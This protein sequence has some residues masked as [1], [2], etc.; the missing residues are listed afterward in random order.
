MEADSTFQHLQRDFCHLARTRVGP[1][2]HPS[3]II[4]PE[5]FSW[6]DITVLTACG[7]RTDDG[8]LPRAAPLLRLAT[9]HADATRVGQSHRRALP[10]AQI[11]VETREV[12][13]GAIHITATNDWSSPSI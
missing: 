11:A 10:R 13:H 9:R 7:P 8:G 6:R 5:S 4:L 1:S 3:G 2:Y 12:E